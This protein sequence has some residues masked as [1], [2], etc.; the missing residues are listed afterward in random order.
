MEHVI[1][2]F[3]IVVEDSNSND[4]NSVNGID[5]ECVELFVFDLLPL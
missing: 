5:T 4:G 1:D 3:V 2:S